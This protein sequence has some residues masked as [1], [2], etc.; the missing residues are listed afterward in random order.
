LDQLY[1]PG[2]TT[3]NNGTVRFDNPDRHLPY[4]HQASLG[5]ERQM[6]GNIAVS[7]D[8]VHASHRDL[9]MLEEV[10]PGVRASTGR[11]ATVTRIYPTSQFGGSVQELVNSGTFEYNAL[12][13]S[14]QK[15]YSNHY[16]VRLS[17]TLSRGRGTARAPGATDTII[18][19]TVDPVTKVSDQH[20]DLFD[21]LGDQ[22]RPHIISLSG[23]VEVPHTKGLNVSGVW[24]YNSGTPFTL[25]SQAADSNRNGLLTDEVLPAGTYSGA[26]NNPYAITVENA[27]GFNGARGPNFS[28]ASVRAAYQF[29]LPGA[30]NR[31]IRVYLDVFNVTNRANYNNPTGDQFAPATFLILR[32]IR[33]GGPSRTAQ[34]NVRYDF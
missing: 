23:A 4:A 3:K 17:Y 1:P 15:R 8:Y 10:N 22:D 12:Q 18:T 30:A 29:N 27:G 31:R 2:A 26:A 33:N 11:T 16:Q 14:I 9:Y 25:F 5:F 7:A 34:F 13:A 19:H 21:A 32:S 6:A 28:L 20:L 24:Q